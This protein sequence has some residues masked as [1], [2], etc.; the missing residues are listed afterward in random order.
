MK[1][2]NVNNNIIEGALIE[3]FNEDTLTV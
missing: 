1:E 3:K 2:N